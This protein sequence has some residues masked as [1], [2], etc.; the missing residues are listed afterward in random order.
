MKTGKTEA[1]SIE[2]KNAVV[3]GRPA[4]ITT[5]TQSA[6][7]NTY[8][9]HRLTWYST[10]GKRIMKHFPSRKD[11]NHALHGLLQKDTIE[12]KRQ[13]I[14][15]RRIGEAGKRLDN[16][17]LWDAAEAIE[18]L[19][20]RATLV[21]A[22]REYAE[23]HPVGPTETI[24]ETCDRYIQDMREHGA[25]KSS[26]RDKRSKF[27]ILCRDLGKMPT[28]QLDDKTTETWLKNRGYGHATTKSHRVAIQNLRNFYAGRKRARH[29][30]DETLPQTWSV[31][32]VRGLFSVAEKQVPEIIPAMVALWFAGV[33]PD[34]MLRLTWD[35]V[36]LA[37]K[38][39]HVPPEAAKTRTSRVVDL[40]DSAVEWLI[41]H[42]RTGKLISSY[43][44]Y[45][46]LRTK[47]QE[48][49]KI[50]EWPRDCPRHTFATMLYKATENLNRTME[51]LGHFGSS[52]VFVRHYK[53]QPVT[54]QQAAEYFTIRPG[55][56][57]PIVI[58]MAQ[59]PIE[60]TG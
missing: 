9:Y 20:G 54:R 1:A 10:D 33:R 26:I 50:P 11:A 2:S 3:N 6:K 27:G 59:E 45:R 8:R 29:L 16:K 42:R 36:D 34:E 41:R 15:R 57:N 22:A 56:G 23:R 18:I 51:Q 7:G 43:P 55:Q 47:L 53:G 14:I 58:P 21:Q 32:K 30:N 5:V 48:A 4:A 12:T 19:A 28:I 25:R 31:E 49:L 40:G 38:S 60:A 17:R 46:R 44:T 39:L 37:T 35:N 24:Q 52:S 13:Q